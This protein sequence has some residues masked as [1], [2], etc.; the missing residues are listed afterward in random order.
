MQV[1]CI[2]DP[3]DVVS[4]NLNG[5]DLIEVVYLQ[6]IIELKSINCP[7]LFQIREEDMVL[8][9]NIVDINANENY[10]SL[11]NSVIAMAFSLARISSN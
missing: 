9:D 7:L 4:V 10:L 11:G 5:K 3:S 2:E 6:Y 1:C 8:F